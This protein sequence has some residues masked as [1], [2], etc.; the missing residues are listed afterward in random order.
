M[1]K[2]VSGLALLEEQDGAGRA[3]TIGDTVEFNCRIFLSR[4]DE[5]LVSRHAQRTLLGKRRVIAGIE[6]ALVGMRVGGIRKVRVSPH[7]AYGDKG[8]EGV[9]PERA[10]LYITLRL[11][12]IDAPGT[13]DS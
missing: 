7:L 10:V 8:V 4:G 13:S 3:A 12:A 2:L 1:N 6:R 9:I 5:V 11:I